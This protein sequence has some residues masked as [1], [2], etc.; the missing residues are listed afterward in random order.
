MIPRVLGLRSR[1][2]PLGFRWMPAGNGRMMSGR[3]S[4]RNE[5]L[6]RRNVW[7]RGI[8]GRL[9]VDGRSADRTILG[10]VQFRLN[11][12]LSH[13]WFL[14]HQ[15]VH[16]LPRQDTAD[17]LDFALD[18]QASSRFA[19]Q[20]KPRVMAQG[21]TLKEMANSRLRRLLSHNQT[22]SEHGDGSD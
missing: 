15:V 16:G 4:V 6:G 17:E 18:A 10:G 7:A 9:Y 20:W 5:L 12:M 13:D 1:A 19:H 11:A 21:A 3:I 14:A 2:S 8:C 22:F